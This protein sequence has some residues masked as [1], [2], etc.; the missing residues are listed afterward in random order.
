MQKEN[1]V[2]AR[3][4]ASELIVLGGIETQFYSE[5]ISADMLK[6]LVESIQREA[7]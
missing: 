5:T 4:I 2:P 1:I 3:Q 7:K 6:T